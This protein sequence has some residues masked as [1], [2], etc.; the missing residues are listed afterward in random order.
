MIGAAGNLTKMAHGNYPAQN[1]ILKVVHDGLQMTF[2]RALEVEARYFVKLIDSKEAKNMI[3][4]GFFGIQA[5]KKGKARPKDQAKYEVKKLGILGAGMMGA[6][7][8]YVSA[9]AGMDVVLKDVTTEGA[10]KGKAYSKKLLDKAISRNRSTP[11]KAQAL[12]ARRE[13]GRLRFGHR[14]RL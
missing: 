2:D 3:R 7:I 10:E 5:A 11:E 4:T 12:L 13:H 14:S 8:A 9:K 1:Y 6:G